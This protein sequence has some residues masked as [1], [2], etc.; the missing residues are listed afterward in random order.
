MGDGSELF[1]QCETSED[2]FTGNQG[3]FEKHR[4]GFL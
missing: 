1:N 3:G 4:V 2:Y